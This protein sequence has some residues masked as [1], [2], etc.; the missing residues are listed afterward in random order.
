MLHIRLA[1]V[2]RLA[3]RRWDTARRMCY[4]PFLRRTLLRV[5]VCV[6]GALIHPAVALQGP[7]SKPFVRG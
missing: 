5:G 2:F 7:A 1:T 4:S 3:R 6:T